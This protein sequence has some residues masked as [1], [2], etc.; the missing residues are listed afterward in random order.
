MAK[1]DRYV[2]LLEFD[3]AQSIEREKELRKD[4]EYYRGKCERLELAIATAGNAAQRD[5]SA[6]SRAPGLLPNIEHI[7]LPAR[8]SF[9]DLKRE[10]NELSQEQQEKIV[11]QGKWDTEVKD[12]GQ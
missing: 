7:Q 10:W 11:E 1:A 5:Y 12:A 3:M 2:K 4:L 9:A 8:K 6:Q